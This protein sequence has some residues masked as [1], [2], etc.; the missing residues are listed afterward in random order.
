M[1]P[2]KIHYCWFSGK[3]IPAQLQQYIGTWKTLCP[4]YEIIRWDESNYDIHKN[5][6]MAAAY[7]EKRWGFVPDYARFDIIFREGGF[8]LDTDVELRRSLDDMRENT[9]YFGFESETMLNAGLGFGAEAGNPVIGTLRDYYDDLSFYRKDG[10]L[11]LT[12]SP[13]YVSNILEELGVSRNGQL[14]R[15]EQVTVYPIDYFSAKDYRTG[16]IHVTPRTYSVHHFSCTWMTRAEKLAEDHRLERCVRYGE[17]LGNRVDG[18][19]RRMSSLRKSHPRNALPLAERLREHV[20]Y[21][22][23][24]NQKRLEAFLGQSPVSIKTPRTAVVLT[25]AQGLV[26]L[27]DQL[28]EQA[29]RRHVP[30][31]TLPNG[32]STHR[33]PSLAAQ[34]RMQE[35]ELVLV[36]GSNLLSPDMRR[37]QWKLPDDFSALN[38][39]CLM[40]CGLSGDG[41]VEEWTARF[42][43]RLL[44]NGLLHSVRDRRTETMLR[45]IGVENVL[46]TAC[47]TMWDLTEVHCQSVPTRKSDVA[48]TALTFYQP[49]PVQDSQQLQI[50]LESYD[51]LYFWP[52]SA[53]DT[54]YLMELLTREERQRVNIL[55]GDWTVLGT[56]LEQR[57]PDYIGNRLHAGIFA[58]QHGCRSRIIAIDHRAVDLGKDTQLPVLP[59]EALDQLLEASLWD[60]APLTLALP[61]ENIARWKRQ[62]EEII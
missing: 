42:Y 29:C 28:I 16:E 1:I 56:L 33:P 41:A 22:S 62:F 18:L 54:H 9:C 19:S 21:S 45:Q 2:K 35:A 31:Q 61:W 3:A 39:V 52:Q 57:R 20:F 59:R 12:P 43:E 47:P 26:N 5:A 53:R 23:A 37:G 13:Y 58:L 11:N 51:E 46:Y 38:R 10:S 40:G 8:Y 55:Q 30:L 6:Y 14:Q 24:K 44:G 49:D 50:L 48:V 7:R 17:F 15:L 32:I 4:D 25:P 60:E 36:A 34:R 27:G